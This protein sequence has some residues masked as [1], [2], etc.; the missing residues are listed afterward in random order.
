MGYILREKKIHIIN[1]LDSNIQQCGLKNLDNYIQLH[2]QEMIGEKKKKKKKRRKLLLKLT[3]FIQ[4]MMHSACLSGFIR[5][6]KMVFN[7]L[8][9]F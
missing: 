6:Y 1:N 2:G 5:Y 9:S 4:M 8:S 3:I 7:I